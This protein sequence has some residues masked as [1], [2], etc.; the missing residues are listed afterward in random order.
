MGKKSCIQL[1]PKSQII[2]KMIIVN[3]HFGRNFL[4]K[5]SMVGVDQH[6]GK[7]ERFWSSQYT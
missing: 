4:N 3:D 5:L 6:G 7:Q 1:L 2:P